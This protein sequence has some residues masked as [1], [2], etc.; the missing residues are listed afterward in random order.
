MRSQ[1][2]NIQNPRH[3][4]KCF[5]LTARTLHSFPPPILLSR[6]QH[7][8]TAIAVEGDPGYKGGGRRKNA[9]DPIHIITLQQMIRS[10]TFSSRPSPLAYLSRWPHRRPCGGTSNLRSL[11]SPKLAASDWYNVMDSHGIT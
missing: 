11:C 3:N 4:Q 8:K 6:V 9:P 2:K 5:L 10:L 7:T 1:E